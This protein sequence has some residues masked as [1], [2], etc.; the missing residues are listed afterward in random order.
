MSIITLQCRVSCG[1]TE[2][3]TC[4]EFTPFPIPSNVNLGSMAKLRDHGD[5][6]EMTS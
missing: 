6:F 1:G 3:Y 2:T 5:G 4:R